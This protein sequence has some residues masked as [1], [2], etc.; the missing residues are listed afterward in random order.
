MNGARGI[1]PQPTITVSFSEAMAEPSADAWQLAIGGNEVPASATVSGEK[2]HFQPEPDAPLDAETE[3][4][5]QLDAG[6]TDVV[7]NSL[8][9]PQSLSFTTAASELEEPTIHSEPPTSPFYV[10]ASSWTF[11]GTTATRTK[12]RVEGGATTAEG[13]TDGEGNFSVKVSLV[14]NRLNRLILTAEDWDRNISS[15]LVYE[16]VGDCEPPR[17]VSAE[18][19]GE[20]IVVHF[21]EP[22]AAA[23]VASAITVSAADGP[24]AGVIGL[25]GEA[26]ATFTPA[27]ATLPAGGL[28]LA[29]SQEVTDLAGNALVYPYSELF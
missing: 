18:S 27:A 3:V 5:L 4:T 19:T 7:G 9:D 15:P 1:G 2:I 8:V 25:T 10:C 14:P 6:L 26:E 24:V 23:T 28:L 17:V 12:V 21:S 29:V 20:E 16:I 13:W 11:S 22:V